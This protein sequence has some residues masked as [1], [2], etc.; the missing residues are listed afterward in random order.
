MSCFLTTRKPAGLHVRGLPSDVGLS[1]CKGEANPLCCLTGLQLKVNQYKKGKPAFHAT[2]TGCACV[3]STGGTFMCKTP[4]ERCDGLHETSPPPITHL[5]SMGQA[6]VEGGLLKH[7][8]DSTSG[9]VEPL[10]TDA[11]TL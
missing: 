1:L 7:G 8:F 6:R 11:C 3:F 9:T 4:A 2:S 5:R 10:L